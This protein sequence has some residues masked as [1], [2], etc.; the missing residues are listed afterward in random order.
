MRSTRGIGR[1]RHRRGHAPHA[2]STLGQT[3]HAT[4]LRA[5]SLYL[6]GCRRRR[7]ARRRRPRA[8]QL[9]ARRA[10]QTS[11]GHSK[12]RRPNL[13]KV[14]SAPGTTHVRPRRL[15]PE[16]AT[17]STTEPS[18]RA[19]LPN[20]PPP[21]PRHKAPPDLAI[22]TSGIRTH[23]LPLTERVLCQ[24]SY[25]GCTDN[26]HSVVCARLPGAP[27]VCHGRQM[28]V[29]TFARAYCSVLFVPPASPPLVLT[30]TCPDPRVRALLVT[31]R[32]AV[33]RPTAS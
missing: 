9:P 12:T 29:L 5:R 25:S 13:R 17:A 26:A 21:D 32:I 33:L 23:D 10:R 4:G 30:S 1:V 22:A 7:A 14:R 18:E 11:G 15:R 31:A 19:L 24:L 6:E 16:A 20:Q 27:K 28:L 8:D 2:P 3:S